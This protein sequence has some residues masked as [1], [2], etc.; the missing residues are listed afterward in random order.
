MEQSMMKQELQDFQKLEKVSSMISRIN[1]F[2]PLEK[3]ISNLD[4]LLEKINAWF[5]E[6]ME[7]NFKIIE[8][9]FNPKNGYQELDYLKAEE[10]LIYLKECKNL[11]LLSKTSCRTVLN[12]LETYL[13]GYSTFIQKE[14]NT[15]FFNIQ[16]YNG[17]GKVE[18]QQKKDLLDQVDLLFVRFQEIVELKGKSTKIFGYF[19]EKIIESWERNFIV[20]LWELTDQITQ[21][22]RENQDSNIKL[23]IAKMLSRFDPYLHDEKFMEVYN[24][25]RDSAFQ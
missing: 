16:H 15:A 11:S 23:T 5:S 6:Q 10:S 19:P 7:Y 13:K 9:D 8:K 22:I 14:M 18:T 4:S 24:K 3:C 21:L 2:K 25:F 20:Y 17:E 12:Q 1:G